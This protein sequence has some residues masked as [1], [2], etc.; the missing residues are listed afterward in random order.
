M[1]KE[2]YKRKYDL[3][4]ESIDGLYDYLEK[5]MEEY[6][7]KSDAET[8]KVMKALFDG[9]I[10]GYNIAYERLKLIRALF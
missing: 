6:K 10:L 3:L 4:K 1:E 9:E 5:L 8:S 7:G 2:Y